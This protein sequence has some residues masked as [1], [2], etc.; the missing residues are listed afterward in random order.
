MIALLVKC[1]YKS[2]YGSIKNETPFS[3]SWSTTLSLKHFTGVYSYKRTFA[4]HSSYLIHCC[5]FH[6]HLVQIIIV[7]ILL[8]K[9]RKEKIE[10]V[11]F[12]PY[13]FFFFLNLS[14]NIKVSNYINQYTGSN[15][16]RRFCGWPKTSRGLTYGLEYSSPVKY[17]HGDIFFFREF[18]FLFS[19]YLS[20]CKIWIYTCNTPGT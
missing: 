18:F 9:K 7:S 16:K 17:C 3:N 14:H 2:E 13:F 19:F 11:L 12:S 1:W 15:I 10:T 20:L 5:F 8:K 4:L 6:F